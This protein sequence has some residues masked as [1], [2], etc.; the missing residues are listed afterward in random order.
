MG[1]FCNF[2]DGGESGLDIGLYEILNVLPDELVDLH[3]VTSGGL[4]GWQFKDDS[5]LKEKYYL[6]SEWLVTTVELSL[7][8]RVCKISL[9]CFILFSIRSRSLFLSAYVI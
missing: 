8:N 1:I 3:F 9:S 2:V 6:I 4:F 7:V 5:G